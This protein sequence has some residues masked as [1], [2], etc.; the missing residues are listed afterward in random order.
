MEN[1]LK[2]FHQL[3]TF[4]QRRRIHRHFVKKS[5]CKQ[6]GLFDNQNYVEKSKQKHCGYLDERNYIKK[7]TWKRHGFFDHRNYI[8]KS[9][10]KQRGFFNHQNYIQ[11]SAWKQRGFFHHQNYIQKS[12]WKQRG[13]FDQRNYIEK[14]RGNCVE[15]RRNLVFPMPTQHP[16][17]IDVDLT[18]SAGWDVLASS[19]LVVSISGSS[20]FQL[21]FSLHL[22]AQTIAL[23]SP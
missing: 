2:C 15:T 16:R 17:R 6:S 18:W 13:F 7:S 8:E 3:T 4:Q 20:L 14:V 23:F 12:R 10:W 1:S 11:K 21:L 22:F 5:T 19:V 9:T